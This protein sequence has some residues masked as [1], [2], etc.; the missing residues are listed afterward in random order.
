MVIMSSQQQS[1]SAMYLENLN[2]S[3]PT[4]RIFEYARM[5]AYCGH[6][7]RYR[8]IISILLIS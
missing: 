7:F 3:L 2:I 6:T 4:S 8:F 1:Q 5:T